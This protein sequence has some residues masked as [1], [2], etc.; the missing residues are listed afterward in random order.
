M[1]MLMADDLAH[2]EGK[3]EYFPNAVTKSFCCGPCQTCQLWRQAELQKSKG[4]MRMPG[5][6]IPYG[7]LVP[8]QQNVYGQAPSGCGQ[9]VVATVVGQPVAVAAQPIK[10]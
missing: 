7:G 8:Y 10:E 6:Q 5:T 4:L 1:R 2:L 9:P 3:V